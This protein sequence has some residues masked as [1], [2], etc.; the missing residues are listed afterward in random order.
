MRKQVD[1]LVVGGG[2]AGLTAAMA[3]AQRGVDFLAV[4]RLDARQETSRA[5]VVHARTLEV[6]K[7]FDVSRRLVEA[8]R[9]VPVFTVRDRDT[10][11]L[12]IDFSQLRTAFPF[13]LMVPQNE[14]EA[15]F[16]ARLAEL[17]HGLHRGVEIVGLRQEK[18]RV[19]ATT[20]EGDEI[21]ARCVVGAD[22]M[23]SRVREA[24]GIEFEGGSYG[25][26]FVL[27]DVRMDWALDPREVM[28]FFSGEGL[29][30]VAPL[31]GGRHRI[32]ATAD[33]A[34][35]A[36]PLV[37]M[38]AILAR[39]GPVRERAAI[40]EIVWSSRF[41]VHHRIAARFVSGRIFLAGDAAHVHSPA[42]GQGMNTGIQDAA[43]LAALLGRGESY[44][45]ERLQAY[46]SARRPVAKDVVR[47]TDR[48]TRIA[49]LKNR[50]ARQARNGVISA[51]GHLP[52]FRSALARRLA[53]L[54]Y[55]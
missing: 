55:R 22:G 24:A 29:V 11:L 40:R 13:T 34:P 21:D 3:L 1:V 30:V 32:V 43:F 39:R 36:P 25:Q 6:L 9:K 35:E 49:T 23:H 7:E 19:T 4:E 5:A 53:E 20:A 46:E 17:G 52:P 47:L 10:V 48:M 31:P 50:Q 14:T 42:G 15:I 44:D 45:A 26:S 33:D 54:D 28:L 51:L 38:Q 41:H 18:D 12:R 8:G 16:E 37:Y 2:P 27:A